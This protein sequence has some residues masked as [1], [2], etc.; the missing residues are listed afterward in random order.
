MGDL[1]A[2]LRTLYRISCRGMSS[3][4]PHAFSNK[5]FI[6]GEYVSA[7][8]K[9]L[10]VINP[11]T[12]EEIGTMGNA[13]ADDVN[14][15]VEAANK[16]FPAWSTT[17]GAER[18]AI[19]RK[20]S[21][22][23]AKRKSQLAKFETMDM[24]KPIAES[25]WDLDDVA[26]CF[27]YYADMAEE[28]DGRQNT[29]VDVPLDTFSC[30]LQYQALGTI[31]VI[32]PWNYPLLMATWKV[33][34]ALAAGCTV[35][36]KPSEHASLT[37]IELGEI[38]QEAGVPAG[39]LNVLSGLGPEAGQALCTNP[40]VDAM[41]FT[42]S[43]ATGS[44]IMATAAK[45]IKNVSL[46]LGG[47]G[48]L[49][50]F[51]DVDVDKAVEWIMFGVFWTNGQICS[52][53]SRVLLHEKIAPAVLKR[54]K[55][56]TERI[57]QTNPM[58]ENSRMGPVVNKMQY[59][60][61]M[62]YIQKG[63]DEGATLLTGGKRCSRFE[64]GYFVEPTVFT[65]VTTDM[66]I[67]KEEIFGPVLAVKT[68]STEE[69]AI[70]EANDSPY[71]LAAGVISGDKDRCNRVAKALRFG[72]VWVNCS[73]PCFFTAPWGGL[74]RSGVGRDLGRYG[75]ERFLEP[76]QITTYTSDEPWGWFLDAPSKL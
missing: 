32:T 40:G 30:R 39:V 51:D 70:F 76:K 18:A 64:K 48:A 59:D 19:L 15:A 33:A 28:L 35:V 1:L 4:T 71:G 47:K 55:E 65:D 41:A 69:Q 43:T 57:N 62:G 14:R 26:D 49:V 66:T 68:F 7:S 17:T 2:M 5:I 20:F 11:A 45:Q 58:E 36:L 8:L 3:A 27:K 31:G 73:Q 63:K 46:E 13:S 25:E 10:P 50:I 22:G 9:P 16:A 34:P 61:V 72:I 54:L 24:G 38:A 60:K 21:E 23:L 56:E 37:C 12:E 75:F 52:S 6:N 74:K 42:G 29:K 67:W 53:T 44:Y